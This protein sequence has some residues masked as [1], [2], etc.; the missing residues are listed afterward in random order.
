MKTLDDA[1]FSLLTCYDVDDPEFSPAG[2]CQASL[3]TLQYAEPWMSVPPA[4][5]Y[6][7]KYRYA[8]KMIDLAQKVFPDIRKHIEEAEPATPL[9]HM[10]YLG[11]PGGSIYGSDH[12]TRET[13]M[14]INSRS[15]IAGLYFTGAWN[16][17]GG[18]QPT[19]QSGA[20]IARTVS[21]LLSK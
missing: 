19:L 5:Y 1:E 21:R 8:E 9:T 18:F 16:G 10:R 4:K 6:D 17:A 11:H 13:S 3:V 7:A 20:S 2:A 14:F 12:F 15:E